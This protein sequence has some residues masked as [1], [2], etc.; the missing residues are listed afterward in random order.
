MMIYDAEHIAGNYSLESLSLMDVIE[1]AKEKWGDVP[2]LADWAGDAAARVGGKWE[3]GGETVFAAEYWAL[4]LI[5][6]YANDDGVT[7]TEIEP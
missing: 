5:E 6:Q 7:L 4:S 1:R 2:G 3:S